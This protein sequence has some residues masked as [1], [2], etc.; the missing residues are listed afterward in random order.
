MAPMLDWLSKY[1]DFNGIYFK[2]KQITVTQ[3]I[4]FGYALWHVAP[5]FHSTR[6]CITNGVQSIL[7]EIFCNF[8]S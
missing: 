7:C 3:T 6:K 5:I 2:N 8:N 1:F 4:R